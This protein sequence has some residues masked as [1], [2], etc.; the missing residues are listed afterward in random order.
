[1]NNSKLR[2]I[3]I[4]VLAL[5]VI[6]GVT[7]LIAS[8]ANTSK[9][10]KSTEQEYG[11]VNYNQAAWQKTEDKTEELQSSLESAVKAK[12]SDATFK[13]T[14]IEGV[15][16]TVYTITSDTADI[17]EFKEAVRTTYIEY[18]DKGY[19]GLLTLKQNGKVVGAYPPR[20]PHPNE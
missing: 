5:L 16:A 6:G 4:V 20:Q 10:N 17:N 13:L 15:D 12:I 18:R 11:G 8:K 7:A 2:L 14:S 1:M 19:K 9:V 3:L